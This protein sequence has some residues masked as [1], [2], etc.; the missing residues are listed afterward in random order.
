MKAYVFPGQG[1]QSVG[2]GKDLFNK[3]PEIVE[4]SNRILGYD[5]CE[6]CLY[7]PE[8]KLNFTRYTQPALY[9]VNYLSYLEYS[10]EHGEPD[11]VAGHSLGEFDALCAAGVFSFEVGLRL[12]KKRAELMSGV[13]GGGMAA[14]IGLDEAAV[15]SVIENG[16][17]S[18]L[19]IANIN[20]ASQI[21]ISGNAEAIAECEADFTEM[22]ARYVVLNVSG[23]FHSGY[24]RSSGEQLK[25]F[26]SQFSY[27][28]PRIT[29]ISNHTARPYTLDSVMDNMIRQ[30]Y[31]PVRWDESVHYMLHFMGCDEIVQTG[32]G[33]VLT[34]MIPKIQTEPAMKFESE[35][36]GSG[37]IRIKPEQLGNKDFMKRYGLKYAYIGGAMYRGISSA[38]MVESFAKAG[39]L[40]FFGAGGY[41]INDLRRELEDLVSR[42]KGRGPFGINV[43]HNAEKEKGEY[44][45]VELALEFGIH[46][47]EA[48][49]YIEVNEALAKYK[50]L[51]LHYDNNGRVVSDNRI[52]VKLSRPEVAGNF[53]RP[54]PAELVDRLLSKGEIT[55]VQAEMAAHVPTA[56][57]ITVEADS[58][59]H[60]DGGTAF[61]LFPAIASLRTKMEKQYG[62][63]EHIFVGAAGGIGSPEAALACF[64]MGADYIVT[65]SINQCTVEA[66]TSDA[67]KDILQG[68]GFQDMDYAPAGDA[69]GSGAKVQVVKRGLLF[70]P[71]A[72]KLYDLYLHYNSIDEIDP[73]VRRQLQEK[74][75][76]RSFEQI[77]EESKKYYSDEELAKAEKNPKVRMRIIFK[78]YF[79]YTTRLAKEGLLSDKSNFQI[80]CGPAMG[81]FNEL[82]KG[83]ELESWK[84][85]RCMDVAMFI[86]NGAAELL[87]KRLSEFV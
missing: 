80:N 74:Y 85:R 26:A 62:Y 83:T 11:A 51:G 66:G 41:R 2:M 4:V 35:K 70:A 22:G 53:L 39:C 64:M 75:F 15:R 82:V 58:G 42:I 33:H 17:H 13:S 5:I 73:N 30:I 24:M 29:V 37:S 40:C 18:G 6:L 76:H 23:P 25:E 71:R 86:M 38:D 32:P 36:A 3:Y 56:D 7:D 47:I 81:T 68:L 79:P 43:I 44:D 87:S 61:A 34:A 20:T 1:S 65:G 10:K 19:Y 54:I 67:V 50:I 52:M 63:N 84:N 31:S 45:A 59:G 27:S 60:T 72:N 49:A 48:A 78:A 77:Y 55:P 12:I 28:A 57:D 21:V 9:V 16:R 8:N 14:V 46:C 69:F